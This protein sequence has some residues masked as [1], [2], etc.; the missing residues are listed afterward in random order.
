MSDYCG[1]CKYNKSDRTGEQACPFNFFYWDFLL[2]HGDRLK[3]LGRMNLVL[4][5]IK[6]I[7]EP[8]LA[9]ITALAD[10]WWSAELR[11]S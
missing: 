1:D 9:A 4:S 5:H 3:S 10:Q 7:S 8:E 11:E 2:R 6:R